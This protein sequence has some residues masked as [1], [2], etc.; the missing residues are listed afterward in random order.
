MSGVN[1]TETRRKRGKVEYSGSDR[2]CEN[3]ICCDLVIPGAGILSDPVDVCVTA[4]TVGSQSGNT[5]GGGG[6][7]GGRLQREGMNRMEHTTIL[8]YLVIL[9]CLIFVN[10]FT[11]GSL[12]T[13]QHH[14]P[15]L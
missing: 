11:I 13:L 14:H 4:I 9:V 15:N 1:S 5:L 10:L 12:S 3:P 7:G 8:V 2:I 6:G